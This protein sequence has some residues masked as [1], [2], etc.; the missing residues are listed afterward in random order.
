MDPRYE[1]L[2][3]GLLNFGCK[4]GLKGAYTFDNR[5]LFFSADDYLELA[6]Y[7]L[8]QKIA[9]YEPNVLVTAGIGGLPLVST[10]KLLAKRPGWQVPRDLAVVYV[11]D[12]QKDHGLGKT[13]E[14]PALLPG[15]RA[16][17]IDDIINSG[18]TYKRAVTSC[19]DAGF[20]L[21]FVAIAVVVDFWEVYGSRQLELRG[22]PIESLFRRQD[23][24]LTRREPTVTPEAFEVVWHAHGLSTNRK[25]GMVR[26]Q[27]TVIGDR[28][29]AGCDAG[30]L[31][32]WNLESGDLLW[33]HDMVIDNVKGICS[34]PQVKNGLV[35]RTGYDGVAACVELETGITLWH[36]RVGTWVHS[37]PWLEHEAVYVGTEEGEDEGACVALDELTGRELWRTKLD[38]YVPCSPAVSGDRVVIGTNSS[39]LYCLNAKTGLL[40]WKVQTVGEV[41]GRPTVK[42]DT[43]YIATEHG[44]VE[45]RRLSDGET[46]WS[47]RG[48][49]R[50]IQAWPLIADDLL[51]L[52]SAN[53]F[54]QAYER[55]TGDIKWV[56]RTRGSLARSPT[57]VS[58]MLVSASSS[59]Q[60]MVLDSKTGQKLTCQ[61]LPEVSTFSEPLTATA[62]GAIA[63]TPRDGLLR[64]RLHEAALCG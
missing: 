50:Y 49:T 56:A 38:G 57:F 10:L 55:Q 44:Q 61:Q 42:D 20:Q 14:G 59:G 35:Y 48:A 5:E 41:K 19:V 28:V 11:R 2:R 29:L 8:W 26:S 3:K 39:S 7:L 27:A 24:G 25:P 40:E 52:A 15:S 9:K 62:D 12:Q 1:K 37:T 18:S 31:G 13:V 21:E 6:A 33:K 47:K 51:F 22:T 17:F 45:V 54:I 46:I 43:I 34:Q 30:Y 16:V 63:T 36:R 64:L 23:L 58:T 32:C 53:G 4:F 60:L